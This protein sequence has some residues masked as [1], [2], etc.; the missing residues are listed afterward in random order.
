MFLVVGADDAVGAQQRLAVDL[1]RP[2][3]VKWP[4]EKRSAG[5]RVVVKVNRRSVQ[6]WTLS[7]RSSLKALMVGMVGRSGNGRGREAAG[8][9]AIVA[10][11][12]SSLVR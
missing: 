12:A 4:F 5:S 10:E 6:W 7:T 1:R 11:R 3:I 2:I 9:P 8:K